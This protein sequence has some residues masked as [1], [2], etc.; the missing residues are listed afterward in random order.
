MS[1]TNDG[2]KLGDWNVICDV[3]G[4]KLKASKA[5]L[6]WDGLYVCPDDWE[7]RQPLDFVRG[8]KDD[9]SVP[10]TRPDSPESGGNDINGNSFPPSRTPPAGR[11]V[12]P[13]TNFGNDDL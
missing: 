8:V 9:Q 11:P 2:F 13:A 1:I 5:K 3:C 10:Y 6:R 4:V 12:P 7:V